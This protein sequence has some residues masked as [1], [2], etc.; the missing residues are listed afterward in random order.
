M[1]RTV[2]TARTQHSKSRVL[3]DHALRLQAHV[4]T[5]SYPFPSRVQVRP[6]NGGMGSCSLGR[7][8]GALS[9]NSLAWAR[10]PLNIVPGA[11]LRTRVVFII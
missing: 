4:R 11:H 7:M 5:C 9:H 1:L 6:G 10:K 2:C 8:F 3:N